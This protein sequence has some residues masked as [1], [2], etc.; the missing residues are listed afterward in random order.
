MMIAGDGIVEG[1]HAD[2]QDTEIRIFV[3]EKD[4]V[5]RTWLI[6]SREVLRGYEMILV[7]VSLSDTEKVEHDNENHCNTDGSH[8]ESRLGIGQ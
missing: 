8:L 5:H 2:V 4:L 3:L 1:V 6:C 7:E